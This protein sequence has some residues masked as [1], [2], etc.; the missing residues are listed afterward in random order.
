MEAEPSCRVVI[1][2]LDCRSRLDPLEKVG[3]FGLILD[4]EPFCGCR[5]VM[6]N[7]RHPVMQPP[8][9]IAARSGGHR[10]CHEFL[11]RPG[12]PD[13]VEAGQLR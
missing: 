6:Q 8:K 12:M 7:H 11:C 5:V 1:A 10:A 9:R 3:Y 4:V 2:V 13:V